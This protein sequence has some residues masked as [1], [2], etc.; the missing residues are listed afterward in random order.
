MAKFMLILH[1]TPGCYPSQSPE[2]M[3]RVLEKYNAWM[4]K[5]RSA[6]R[7]VESNKLME[8]G[9]KVVALEKGR[10]S[11]VDGPYSEAREVVGGY[12]TIRAESY[13]EVVELTRDCPH[14]LMGHGRIEIRRTD[15][16]GCGGD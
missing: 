7:V 12:I 1:E 10:V 16:N 6:N 9:G 3:Q 8:E 15:P 11:V 2:E 5:F 13:D 14:V 4:E